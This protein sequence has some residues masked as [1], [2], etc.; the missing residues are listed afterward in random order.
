M[1]DEKDR[2]YDAY[3]EFHILKRDS[4]VS[5]LDYVIE[6]ERIYNKMSKLKMKLPDAVPAF[7]LLDTAGLTIKDKQLA[8]T[9][10]ADLTISS[11]KSALTQDI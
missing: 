6:F 2:Q 5:M 4:N 11:M 3:T 7:K 10:C 1:K 8:L 9:A